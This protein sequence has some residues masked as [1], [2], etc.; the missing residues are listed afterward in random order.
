V[1]KI[2]H[3]KH[4]AIDK[5]KWEQTILASPYPLVFAQSF[6]LDATFP[7][8][9]ALVMGDYGSVFPLTQKEKLGI[10]YLH[11]P[12]FT[13]QLGVYGTVN[14]VVEQQFFDY[15]TAHYKL[16]EIELNASNTLQTKDHVAKQTFVIDYQNG[17]KFNQNT[18]RNISKAQENQLMFE[19]I[20]EAEI[21]S[22]SQQYLNPF[23]KKQLRLSPPVIAR[24]DDLLRS[25]MAAG[26]LY[27]FRVIDKDKTLQAIAHFIS[28]GKH[29]VYLKG[30]N[31]DKEVSLGSMHLLNS[32]A[33]R[34]F[35]DKAQLFDFGGGTKESLANFYKGFGATALPYQSLKYN[36]LPWLVN[37]L[38][39]L[40]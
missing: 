23:L 24:F 18:K 31:F 1:S 33:I 40:S 11:Q 6:Y 15:I 9:D 4:N 32:E 27:S 17:Y 25:A 16:I 30:I 37:V 8:W 12:S 3:I 5:V 20:P 22:L 14:T 13:P 38:K 34:F 26:T 39:K 7:G 2:Q 28:N 19:Q 29:T 35:S 10:T 36:R 21:L